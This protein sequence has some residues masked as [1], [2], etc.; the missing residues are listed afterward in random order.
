[1]KGWGTHFFYIRRRNGRDVRFEAIKIN[2]SKIAKP[3]ELAQ[4]LY[5]PY[6]NHMASPQPLRA[7]QLPS[8]SP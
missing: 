5:R 2:I 1:M 3:P 7:I 8:R 4:T 6:T